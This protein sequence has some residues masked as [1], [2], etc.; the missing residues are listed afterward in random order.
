LAPYIDIPNKYQLSYDLVNL[1]H[2][3]PNYIPREM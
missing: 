2:P 3:L 1:K